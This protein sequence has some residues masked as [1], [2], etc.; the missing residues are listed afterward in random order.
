MVEE[1]QGRDHL[2]GIAPSIARL[3]SLSSLTSSLFYSYCNGVGFWVPDNLYMTLLRWGLCD[4]QLIGAIS[5]HNF[6]I[7]QQFL[8]HINSGECIVKLNKGISKS[9][10]YGFIYT[11]RDFRFNLCLKSNRMAETEWS[12]M[13]TGSVSMDAMKFNDHRA[14]VGWGTWGGVGGGWSTFIVRAL[15]WVHIIIWK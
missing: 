14:E 4:R 7:C 8:K 9:W 15:F 3:Y 6:I 11:L 2:I 10:W 1:D 13:M 5:W 12:G